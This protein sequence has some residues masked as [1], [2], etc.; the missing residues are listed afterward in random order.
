[1]A[2]D[3]RELLQQLRR[4][5]RERLGMARR[6]AADAH[7]AAR[8]VA[9]E[10]EK[11]EDARAA[12]EFGSIASGQAQR[13]QGTVEELEQIDRL[14]RREL[15]RFAAN[16]PVGLFAVVDVLMTS[17]SGAEE[18]R[19]FFVLPL[20][21]GTELVGPG[22]DGFLSVITPASPVGK[23]LMGKRAGDGTDVQ[24]KDGLREVEILEVG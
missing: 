10:S 12:L 16:S 24:L 4:H 21:A 17:E 14:L 20:G 19:T 3:K 6:A 11:K 18:G 1:M 22:G 15:P 2:L 23:A 9:T 8:T 7:D 5:Y 13:S